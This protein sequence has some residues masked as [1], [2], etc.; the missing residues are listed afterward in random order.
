MTNP[1]HLINKKT[2]EHKQFG[3]ISFAKILCCY[4]VVILHTNNKFWH[5]NYN[6]YKTYWLS[7]NLI[8][9][10]FYFAV[11]MFALCIGAT[12]LD[13]NERYG[14]IEYYKKRILK[15]VIPMLSWT[16][17]LYFYKIYILKD[18]NKIKFTFR[19]LW[20]LYYGHKVYSIINSLHY[21][22]LLYFIT[23][24]L[25]FVDKSKKIKIYSYCFVAL[26]LGQALFP[27]LINVFDL[28]LIWIYNI[29]LGYMIYLFA[30]YIIQNYKFSIIAKIIIYL[31][32]LFGFLI[33]TIGTKI[34]TLRYGKVIQLHKGYVNLPC[35]LYSCSLFLLIKE[36]SNLIFKLINEKFI[37]K[38]GTLT[39][40]P[41][42]MHTPIM[43]YCIKNFK[44]DLYGLNYR[45]FGGIMICTI[46]LIITFI[47]KNIPLL[48][49]LVP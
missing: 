23:P 47:L 17:L 4:S 9:C 3:Y 1:K 42:F 36:I 14:I 33:H 24:L 13:F 12:L 22:L 40:G 49:Y 45:L 26:L 41:F 19:N 8:E 25:A 39:F 15:I 5:F 31:L 35:V 28:K 7:A 29:D 27:Y 43:D 20:N 30:G 10:I 48:N 37:S 38:I 32:G 18:M 2:A 46:S 6:N 34:L 16:F 21:F 11:P 44:F